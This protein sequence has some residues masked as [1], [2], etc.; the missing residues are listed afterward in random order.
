M[1]LTALVVD[2]LTSKNLSASRQ[3][4]VAGAM[5][6]TNNHLLEVHINQSLP[7]LHSMHRPLQTMKD[8][9]PTNTKLCR[10]NAKT[11]LPSANTI[12]ASITTHHKA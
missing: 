5:A 12:L 8:S 10:I 9:H 3:H 6:G 7:R 4:R 1:G 11:H 2:L